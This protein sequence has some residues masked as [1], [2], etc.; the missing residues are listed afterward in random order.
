MQLNSLYLLF[1]NCKEYSI[2]KRLQHTCL[3]GIIQE[4]ADPLHHCSLSTCIHIVTV[5]HVN[6][7]VT[8]CL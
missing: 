2:L 4:E 5:T 7:T 1:N 6:Y 8:Q 3:S